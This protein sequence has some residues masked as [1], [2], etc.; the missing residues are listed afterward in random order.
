MNNLDT[1]RQNY[2]LRALPTNVYERIFPYL[3]R[4]SLLNGRIL[5]EPGEELHYA[6]FPTTCI[7]SKFMYAQNGGS[8]EIAGVGNEGVIGIFHFMGG[9]SMPNRAIVRSQGYA[10][11]LRKQIF[12]QEFKR[13]P[14]KT[15][16]ESFHYL[17]LRYTQT[18]ITQMA[19]TVVCNRHHSIRQRLC[20][21]LLTTLDRL[22]SNELSITQ[23]LIANMLGVRREG[24]TEAAQKLQS[25]GLIEHH[26]G[27][28][29]VL[30][31][32]GIEDR[33]C[34]CYQV[35]KVEADRLFHCVH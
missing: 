28:I 1:P 20:R 4:V 29:I 5:Y 23:E 13:L 31:R 30:D 2:L 27:H 25:E 33:A 15:N 17:M 34:E 8:T 21:W 19:Q 9:K 22:P 6:Y 18:L 14:E 11:R 12:L 7:V 32:A 24:I 16:E 3:E 35:V 26:R 10:F